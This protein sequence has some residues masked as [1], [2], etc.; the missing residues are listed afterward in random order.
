MR[1]TVPDLHIKSHP[2]FESI[3][4][5]TLEATRLST[6]IIP[7]FMNRHSVVLMYICFKQGLGGGGLQHSR[8][9]LVSTVFLGF[10]F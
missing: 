5:S 10:L 9:F 2:T 7:D 1:L 3:D 6:L 4:R 8:R